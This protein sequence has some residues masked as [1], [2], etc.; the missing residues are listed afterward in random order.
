[1]ATSWRNLIKVE[2]SCSHLAWVAVLAILSQL[3]ANSKN[4]S[5]NLKSTVIYKVQA[6]IAIL[7][8]GLLE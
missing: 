1:M 2:S 6:G 5:S 8:S 7:P 3:T 4:L